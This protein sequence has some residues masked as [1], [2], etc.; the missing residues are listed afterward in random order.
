MPGLI[1]IALRAYGMWRFT[2]LTPYSDS[3]QILLTVSFLAAGMGFLMTPLQTAMLASRPVDKAAQA[4]GIISIARQLGGS[5]GVAILSTVLV[6][7]EK[8]H[9]AAFGQ[10]MNAQDSMYRETDL[11]CPYTV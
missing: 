10:A 6:S 5:F 3:S 4:S 2:F 7:R 8:F 1:G 9:V 11:G